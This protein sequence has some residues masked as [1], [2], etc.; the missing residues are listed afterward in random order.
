M[1]CTIKVNAPT[2][3]KYTVVGDTL[4]AVWKDVLKKGPKDPNDNKKVAALTATFIEIDGKW[5]HEERGGSCRDDGKIEVVIGIKNLNLKIDGTILMPKLG[6]AKL[7]AKAKKE[8]DRFVKKVEA[9]EK[10]HMVV[11]KGVAEKM[12]KEMAIMTAFGVGDDEKKATAAARKNFEKA[13][14]AVYNAKSVSALITAAHKKL[15]KDS[16]HGA[17][18]GASLDTTIK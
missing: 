6:A 10:E 7:S 8:W 4:E 5:T 13:F 15:D 12:D 1:V 2:I 14:V 3:K 18:H 9:H 11:T 16:A 17:K